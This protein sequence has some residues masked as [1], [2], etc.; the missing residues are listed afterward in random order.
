MTVALRRLAFAAA[1]AA[2][3]LVLAAPSAEAQARRGPVPVVADARVAAA[4]AQRPV[5]FA[6]DAPIV[7]GVLV[8]PLSAAAELE[9][10]GAV[11]TAEGRAALGRALTSAR[12]GYGARQTLSLRGVG[13]WDR[14]LVVG[15]GATPT[16]NDVQMSGA[17]A[18]RAVQSDAGQVAVLA[19][20]LTPAQ[21]SDFAA[22]LGIGDYRS[23]L[24]R[25]GGRDTAE[26]GPVLMVTGQATAAQALYARRGAALV[27]AMTW[28]R[29]ISNEPAN[30]VY[31]ETFVERAQAA[32]RGVPGVTIEVLD[33]P[34]MERLGMGAILG[35]G[36]GSPRP[37]RMLI[38]RYR[39][40]GAPEGPPIALV[41]KGIT[42]DSG[43]LSIKPTAG[44]A[45]MKMDM[46]GAA[47]VT[48]AV[49]ALAK[50]GAPV[51]VVAISALAENMPDGAAFRNGDVLTA[52]N[53]KTIEVLS[54]DAE[55]RLVLAD[56]LSWA[57]ANL[58]PA[59]IVDVATL[60]G[61]VVGALG[62]D[63]AGLLTRHDA[64]ADQ[65]TAAGRTTGE[66]LWRLPLHPSYASDISSTIADIKNSSDG[67]GAGT[68][69]WFI[70]NFVR[71]DTPWAHLDIAGMAY[72]GPNDW[73][74]A[75]S[76]GFSVR[77]LDRFVRDWT[78][79]PRGE[80]AGG[81]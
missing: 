17:V 31:P 63:Y 54:T 80:G 8:L 81:R 70:S 15:L 79:I 11:L 18:G 35:V 7:G 30:I 41:G 45:N 51:N 72:G 16:E 66:N 61:S 33:V 27:E 46:S 26:R 43:G 56:A 48:G 71:P 9:T 2:F 78:P 14:V 23:D 75:G 22:G 3:A 38:V 68:A 4:P 40:Q 34:A 44:M 52:M 47:S 59:A 37:P 77:L 28:A 53:G 65:L 42:F 76:A 32:F 57:E 19:E 55:G 73:K 5:R 50:S 60:T 74:P 12:F 6:A 39:G 62:D 10:R 25:T 49:L 20:G 64:L 13:E 69:G 29:D 67:P 58:Q 36:Q 1:P 24:Y 21:A